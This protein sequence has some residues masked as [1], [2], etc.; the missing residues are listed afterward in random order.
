MRTSTSS[1]YLDVESL[2]RRS[3]GVEVGIV[4]VFAA[5]ALRARHQ[6]IVVGLACL[7][8]SD[9]FVTLQC[10]PTLPLL[11]KNDVSAQPQTLRVTL[12]FTWGVG[13]PPEIAIGKSYLSRLMTSKEG[14]RLK[15]ILAL[16]RPGAANAFIARSQE[17]NL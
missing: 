1:S 3:T 15:K 17:H 14:S 12:Q 8:V 5:V 16:P 6:R 10:Y 7:R 13:A 9:S 4:D 2:T 11:I